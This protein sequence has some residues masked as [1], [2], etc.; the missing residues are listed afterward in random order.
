ML[1]EKVKATIKDAAKKLTGTKKRAFMTQVTADYFEG[2]AR[3]AETYLGWKRETVKKG[4]KE[5]ETGIICQDNYQGRGRKKTESKM[6]SLK[7]DI[8]SLVDRDSQAEPKFQTTF[9]YVRV[10]ARPVREALQKEKG[11]TDEELPS[12]PTIGTRLNRIGYRLKKTQKT[13]LLTKILETDDIF[14]NVAKANRNSDEKEKS[15]RISI[16]CKAKVK[17]GRLSRGGSERRTKPLQAYDHDMKWDAVLVPSGILEVNTNEL[18]IYLGHSAE[19]SDFIVNCLEKW[20]AKNQETHPKIEELAINLDGGNAT[21][22]NRTQFK[23]RMVEFSQ[24]SKLK[25]QPNKIK[26]KIRYG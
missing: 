13:K 21:R 9:A 23:K 26:V 16:D 22:S 17:I 19:T 6:P 1:T 7:E 18:S 5:R 4:Q 25:I 2:S 20:W 12:R 11:Y 15:R 24:K 10:R 8:E 3:K 14:A